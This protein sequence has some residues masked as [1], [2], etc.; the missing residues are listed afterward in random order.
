M[1]KACL[2]QYFGEYQEYCRLKQALDICL[3]KH[4]VQDMFKGKK[5]KLVNTT[6]TLLVRALSS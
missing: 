4:D 3:A 1:S 2:A 5:K 6:S